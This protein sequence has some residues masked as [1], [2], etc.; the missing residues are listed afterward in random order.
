MGRI[1]SSLVPAAEK[2]GKIQQVEENQ[3]HLPH[4]QEPEFGVEGLLSPLNTSAV[5]SRTWS[6]NM[7]SSLRPTLKNAEIASRAKWPAYSRQIGMEPLPADQRQH[8]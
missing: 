8:H 2:K 1:S 3:Y 6:S 5:S 7:D 4:K